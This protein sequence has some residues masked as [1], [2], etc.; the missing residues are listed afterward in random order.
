MKVKRF[1]GQL[2]KAGQEGEHWR[3]THTEL[4]TSYTQDT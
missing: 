3:V 4:Y 1:T 2:T